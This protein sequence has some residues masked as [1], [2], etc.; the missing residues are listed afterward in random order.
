MEVR[1]SVGVEAS[2][3]MSALKSSS[4]FNNNSLYKQT[5]KQGGYL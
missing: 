3:E 1:V 4:S 2:R 5:R